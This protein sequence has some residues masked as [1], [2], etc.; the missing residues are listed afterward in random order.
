MGLAYAPRPQTLPR[1]P[2]LLA[3]RFFGRKPKQEGDVQEVAWGD[4]LCVNH[5]KKSG[6][7]GAYE[8]E[9]RILC[10][11]CAVKCL[12]IGDEPSNEQ[13]KTLEPYELKPR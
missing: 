11:N 6:Q 9:G 2:M 12:G 4:R 1:P 7:T 13:Y 5:P 10:R 8:V 3:R